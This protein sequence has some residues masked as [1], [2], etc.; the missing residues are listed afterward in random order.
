[1]FFVFFAARDYLTAAPCF[2]PPPRRR[3]SSTIVAELVR[4]AGRTVFLADGDLFAEE[5]A[6][7]HRNE[8]SGSRSRRSFVV[9]VHWAPA[10][11]NGGRLPGT[12]PQHPNPMV[13]PARPPGVDSRDRRFYRGLCA[14]K[15]TAENR[16]RS[17][18]LRVAFRNAH[19]GKKGP[20][21]SSAFFSDDVAEWVSSTTARQEISPPPPWHLGKIKRGDP[22]DFFADIAKDSGPAAED[23]RVSP[24]TRHLRCCAT[25][26]AATADGTTSRWTAAE[27][28]VSVSSL[29]MRVM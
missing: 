3:V 9:R 11:L 25:I 12:A 21:T 1:L 24:S 18:S 4:A 5:I 13:A 14:R 29:A 17:D 26:R 20:S 7:L 23:L 19:V 10:G 15:S 8:Q 28:A 2:G 27:S 16:L 22:P 6:L